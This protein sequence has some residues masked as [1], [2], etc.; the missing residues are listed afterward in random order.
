MYDNSYIYYSESWIYK[1]K[2]I[3]NKFKEKRVI[4]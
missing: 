4:K 2:V 1:Y 3:V